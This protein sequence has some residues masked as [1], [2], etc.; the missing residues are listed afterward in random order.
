MMMMPIVMDDGIL[1]TE[2]EKPGYV[3]VIGGPLKSLRR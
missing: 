2:S 3:S 1:V